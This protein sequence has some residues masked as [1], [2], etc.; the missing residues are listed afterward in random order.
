MGCVPGDDEPVL[1][2]CGTRQEVELALSLHENEGGYAEL[3]VLGI[4]KYVSMLE[5]LDGEQE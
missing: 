4:A 2:E 5:Q 3:F 1:L